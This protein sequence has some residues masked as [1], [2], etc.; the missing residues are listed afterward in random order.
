MRGEVSGGG[1]ARLGCC[2][3]QKVE[4]HEEKGAGSGRAAASCTREKHRPRV[5][6]HQGKGGCRPIADWRLMH[7]CARGA[8]A[9]LHER[10]VDSTLEYGECCWCFRY[11]R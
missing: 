5:S 2:G 3:G 9:R 7:P 8:W 6:K 10:V 1:G 11:P 4:S